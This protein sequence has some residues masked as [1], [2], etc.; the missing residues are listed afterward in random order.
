MAAQ[1][2]GELTCTPHGLL[3]QYPC[4][5]C[6]SK[7]ELLA[8]IALAAYAVNN[9][10][11]TTLTD[12]LND[13]ACFKCLSDHQMLEAIAAAIIAIAVEYGYFT[14]ANDAIQTAKCLTCEDPA[15]VRGI[16]VKA[17]CEYINSVWPVAV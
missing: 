12:M 15:V 7:T 5:K 11:D 1:D 17:I 10:G 2:R 8:L 4:L 14:D 13:G 6:A 16:S 9:A 3:N